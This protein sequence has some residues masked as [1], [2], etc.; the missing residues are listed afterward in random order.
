MPRDHNISSSFMDNKHSLSL[1]L[2]IIVLLGGIFV[3]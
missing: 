2:L 3:H 1:P